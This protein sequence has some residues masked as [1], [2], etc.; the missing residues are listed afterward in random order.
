MRSRTVPNGG[1][2]INTRLG[3]FE[4]QILWSWSDHY[5]SS[6]EGG[7]VSALKIVAILNTMNRSCPD[8]ER[9]TSCRRAV[10]RRDAGRG[11]ELLTRQ[12][13]TNGGRFVSE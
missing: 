3:C 13:S 4:S 9:W 7:K 6:V 8:G 10:G 5:R 12:V 1:R 11:A 2:V